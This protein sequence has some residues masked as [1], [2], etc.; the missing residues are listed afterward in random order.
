MKCGDQN[1]VFRAEIRVRS[2][3][4]PSLRY[5]TTWTSISSRRWTRSKVE[6]RLWGTTGPILT[7]DASIAMESY[8]LYQLFLS[9]LNCNR[10]HWWSPGEV[11]PAGTGAGRNRFS[12][13]V[14]IRAEESLETSCRRPG[15]RLFNSPVQAGGSRAK[16]QPRRPTPQPNQEVV[17]VG[18]PVP[19]TRERQR[20]K[21]KYFSSGHIISRNPKRRPPFQ[22]NILK[23]ISFITLTI[24]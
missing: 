24:I 16:I 17:V 19:T 1:R 7:Q 2:Q 21:V 13:T 5:F 6:P 11:N 4:R 15:G 14:S 3:R 12:R 9:S 20:R 23:E 22:A 18:S 8:P 10:T